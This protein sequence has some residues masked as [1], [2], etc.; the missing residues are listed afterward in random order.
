MQLVV[1][2]KIH[3]V[4]DND[5]GFKDEATYVHDWFV[6]VKFV[7]TDEIQLA[8]FHE[9]AFDVGQRVAVVNWEHDV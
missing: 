2:F 6:A 3:G 1:P 5:D 4:I 8:P 9:Q 7:Q